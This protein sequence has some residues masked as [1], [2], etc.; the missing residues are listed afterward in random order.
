MSGISHP[1]D[2]VIEPN[3]IQ[4]AQ[5]LNKEELRAQRVSKDAGKVADSKGKQRYLSSR[6]CESVEVRKDPEIC[7]ESGVCPEV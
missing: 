4:E 1:T 6:A 5:S 2:F 3:N 7:R